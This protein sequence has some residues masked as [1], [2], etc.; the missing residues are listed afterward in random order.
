LSKVGSSTYVVSLP[1]AWVRDLEVK[2]DRNRRMTLI[3]RID[4]TILL[5]P[6]IVKSRIPRKVIIEAYPNESPETIYREV[7]SAY[8]VGCNE[9]IVRSKSSEEFPNDT[10]DK[11]EEKVGKGLRGASFS[12]FFGKLPFIAK[13]LLHIRVE[14]SI[15]YSEKDETI[16]KIF[17]TIRELIKSLQQKAIES[18]E[19]LDYAK[20]DQIFK[21]DDKIDREYFYALRALKEAAED[22]STMIALGMTSIRECLGYRHVI[23]NLERIGDHSVRIGKAFSDL[24]LEKTGKANMKRLGALREKLLVHKAFWEEI[25]E[26]SRHALSI[27]DDSI[28]FLLNRE[29]MKSDMLVQE[30]EGDTKGFA[31]IARALIDKIPKLGKNGFNIEETSMLIMVIDSLRRISEYAAG[32]SEVALNIIFY[33]VMI[34]A[35]QE[36]DYRVIYPE[37]LSTSKTSTEPL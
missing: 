6:E 36:G 22:E 7:I 5:V 26:L 23:K 2:D 29:Y 13:E 20:A 21:Y 30:V 15:D 28:E 35:R 17:C 19:S 34:N 25:K 32:I 14:V 18:I 4:G 27:F 11:L 16:A 10:V 37:D 9:I 3:R 8:L 1:K 24:V 31:K 33:G 12:T